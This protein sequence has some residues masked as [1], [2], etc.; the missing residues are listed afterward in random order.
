[1]INTAS[2]ERC[3]GNSGTNLIGGVFEGKFLDAK[4][5]LSIATIPGREVLLA[6]FVNLINSPIQR[7]AIV[8]NRVAVK[9]ETV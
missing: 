6:Q 2:P 4:A 8:L 1:M 3:S 5:M 9:R 7:L